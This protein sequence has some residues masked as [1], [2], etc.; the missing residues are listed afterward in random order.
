M[1]S[2][3]RLHNGFESLTQKHGT[4]AIKSLKEIKGMEVIIQDIRDY[5]EQ[6]KKHN[7]KAW[8]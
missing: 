4:S 2:Y 3:K 1:V 6:I 5:I 8:R 7:R